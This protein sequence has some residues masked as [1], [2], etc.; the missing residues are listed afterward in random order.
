M[1]DVSREVIVIGGGGH[2]LVLVDILRL[3]NVRICGFTDS[4]GDL[5]R[6]DGIRYL[7]DD[8]FILGRDT[9][10]IWLVNG[11]GSASSTAVRREVFLRFQ[12]AGYGFLK[13]IHPSAIVSPSAV[14]NEGVQVMA[15]AVVQPRC[16]IGANVIL[17]TNSSIDH[18]TSIG[19]H[20]H[21][22]PGVTLSGCVDVGEGAHIGTGA[23]VIQN[24]R[25]GAGAL[26]GAGAVVIAE[27][28]AGSRVLGVPA[29]VR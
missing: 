8:Q 23:S 9:R 1:T 16:V 12:R 21:I 24:T 7:G 26:V 6:I 11:I 20:A 22:A 17:N 27:V 25:I 10:D 19:A 4:A 13:I 15:G 5:G 29:S 14:L 18:E 2:A 3:L 28:P